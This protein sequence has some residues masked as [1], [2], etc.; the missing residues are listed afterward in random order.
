MHYFPQQSRYFAVVPASSILAV[1]KP[2]YQ[3][4]DGL[5]VSYNLNR[6]LATINISQRSTFSPTY[7]R[8]EQCSFGTSN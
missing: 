5:S 3:F 2:S 1:E 6:R 7:H 8:M 4:I